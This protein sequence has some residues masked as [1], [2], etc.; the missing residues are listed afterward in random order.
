[1]LWIGC[2]QFFLDV[3]ISI[4]VDM[5][6]RAGGNTV[7]HVEKTS[8]VLKNSDLQ[9]R[10]ICADSSVEAYAPTCIYSYCVFFK[11]LYTVLM[12]LSLLY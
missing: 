2:A 11:Y 5:H 3:H 4:F 6:A 12:W 9:I 7:R 8:P 10:V 1:M